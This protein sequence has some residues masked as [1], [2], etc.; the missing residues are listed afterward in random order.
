[1]EWYPCTQLQMIKISITTYTNHSFYIYSTATTTTPQPT[2]N[3]SHS[4]QNRT[5]LENNLDLVYFIQLIFPS[6]YH[7]LNGN[8]MEYQSIINKQ[9]QHQQLNFILNQHQHQTLLQLFNL[10]Q[11]N[12]LFL[13]L[14]Q[15]QNKPNNINNLINAISH[16]M[17]I[18]LG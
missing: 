10:N 13:L 14:Q 7:C 11:D 18:K 4:V 12:K 3:N 15:N 8:I 5:G 6:N 9:N 2:T 17:M 16:L 1:M